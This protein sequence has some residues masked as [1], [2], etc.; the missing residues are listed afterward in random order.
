MPGYEKLKKQLLD[1]PNGPHDDHADCLAICCEAATTNLQLLTQMP[2][3]LAALRKPNWLQQLNAPREP[4]YGPDV[5]MG[6][7]FCS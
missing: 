3:A 6:E 2:P 7:S 4:E 5:N 1:W